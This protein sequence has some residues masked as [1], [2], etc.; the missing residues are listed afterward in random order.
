MQVPDPD[1]EIFDPRADSVEQLRT[2][3][4]GERARLVGLCAQMTGGDWEAAEDLAQETLLEALRHAHKLRDPG[5]WRPWLTGIARN[6]CLRWARRTGRDRSRLV[7][8]NIED[9]APPLTPSGET[10]KMGAVFAADTNIEAALERNEITDLLDR[11]MGRLP[12]ETRHLLS[13]RFLDDVPTDEL[14][15]RLGL[16]ENALAVRLHRGKR[17]LY[18]LLTRTPD[19]RQQAAAYGLIGSTEAYAWQ[20]TRIWCPRCGRRK[21]LG[22]FGAVEPSAGQDSLR[23]FALACSEC[24]QAALAA[25][26]ASGGGLFASAQMLGPE[27][28]RVL[29]GVK[30]YKPILSRLNTWWDKYYRT[31]LA[32]K[33]ARCLACGRPAQVQFAPPPQIA[34][35]LPGGG[36]PGVYVHCGS[37]GLL[38]F[39]TVVGLALCHP[40]TLRFWRAHPRLRIVPPRPVTVAGRPARLTRFEDVTGSARLDIVSAW[41]DH[42]A[43]VSGS[44]AGR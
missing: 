21:L 42:S 36:E 19:L 34:A 22:T 33:S 43:L 9:A 35:L 2:L 15:A 38:C 20:E 25:S 32:A 41:D 26:G 1:P 17:V 28:P 16:T 6:V 23:E 3:L 10:T 24:D 8:F 14:A 11:A 44:F 13:A 39:S 30:G 4:P 5:L 29:H 12:Q 31:A 18:D 37:C 27:L 7:F 40:E